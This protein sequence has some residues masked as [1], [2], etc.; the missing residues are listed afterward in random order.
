MIANT[1]G[2]KCWFDRY[3][4]S[5]RVASEC[6]RR[7]DEVKNRVGN[8]LDNNRDEE[9]KCLDFLFEDLEG[10]INDLRANLEADINS[11]RL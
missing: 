10:E 11:V 9:W 2:R 4:M 3:V 6:R 1:F 7:V 5:G 8:V